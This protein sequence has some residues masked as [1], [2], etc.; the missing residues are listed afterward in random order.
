MKTFKR[1]TTIALLGYALLACSSDDAKTKPEPAPSEEEEVDASG[2][3]PPS[4]EET[5]DA[6]EEPGTDAV[7]LTVWV[8][9]LIDHRTTNAAE[10]DTVDDKV[11]SDDTDETSFDKY[12]P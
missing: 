12:L 4:G 5:P 8:D 3:E 1:T 10:P 7:P 11:I 2:E 6:G 9:D